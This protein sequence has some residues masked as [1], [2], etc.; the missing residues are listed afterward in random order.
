MSKSI[1]GIGL[2]LVAFA[3]PVVGPMIGLSVL[4]IAATQVGI[5]LTATLLLGPK[6]PSLPKTNPID[7]LY[8]NLD[9]GAPRKIIFGHTAMPT[10]MRYQIF[11]GE[12]DQ[13]FEEIICVASHE[14][15]SIDEIWFDNEL[16][17]SQAGG[18]TERYTT[19][20]PFLWVTTRPLATSAN[21]IAINSTWTASS[22]LTGCAYVYMKMRLIDDGGETNDSPFASGITN[23]M[24]IRGKGAK[25]YDP[26][27]DST[28]T[29]GSGTQRANDQTT[30]TY[31]ST[32]GENPA[33]QLLWY[34]IG[35]KINSK[36]AVGMGMP[37]ARIDL[38]SFITAANACDE[39]VT[40]NGGGTEKRYL[41]AGVLSE[42]DDRKAVVDT[43]CASMNA[44]LRDAGGKISINVIYN[45]LASP[46]VT[47]TEDDILGDEMWE[48]TPPLTDSFNICRGRRVDPSDESLYQMVDFPEVGFVSN[49]GIDRIE[50][51]EFPFVQGNGQA[52]RLAKQRLQRNQYQGRYTAQFNQRALQANVGDPVRLSHVGLGWTNKLFRVIAQTVTR[53]SVIKLVLLE[54]NA[55]IYQ[56]DNDEE[57]AVLPGT[58]TVYDPRN[59]PILVGIGQARR[60]RANELSDIDFR[61]WTRTAG[62]ARTRRNSLAGYAAGL[63]PWHLELSPDTA[64]VRTAT[65]PNVPVVA[66]QRYYFSIKA[67]RGTTLGSGS[68]LNLGGDWLLADGTTTVG[69][70]VEGTQQS[71]TSLTAGELPKEIAWSDVAPATAAYVRLRIYTPALASSSGTF[72]IEAPKVTR[73]EPSADVTRYVDGPYAQSFRYDYTGVAEAGEFTRNLIYNLMTAGGPLASGVTWTYLVK[74]GTVNG[75]NNAS[76]VKSMTGTGAGTLAVSSLGSSINIV[77]VT[78]TAASGKTGTS[79]VTLIKTLAAAPTGGGGGGSPT[80]IFSK[81]SGYF[82]NNTTTFVDVTGS[83]TATTT[84]G[85]TTA[86]ITAS[87]NFSPA[88]G[89]DGAWEIAAKVQRNITG[90]WTDKGSLDT[91]ITGYDA[92]FGIPTDGTIELSVSDTGLTGGT[93]YSWRIVARQSV[94][95]ARNHYVT[96]NVTIVG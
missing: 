90:V 85:V 33:L 54:E 66:G 5:A 29:G 76:G 74:T 13:Y 37:P 4:A 44:I 42:A 26:R 82:A 69:S 94:G 87:L 92:E 91:C 46:V 1:I 83:M 3:I 50:T 86:T 30:W 57:P 32:S 45:D 95:G 67:Q 17:W 96:G 88:A 77:E 28:V 79:T 6:T 68:R 22:T 10:D 52:Q 21:G 75:F 65:S 56:W 12:D 40:K 7:R 51:I 15:S 11:S 48:Q 36:L 80:T 9:I 62:I 81:T 27:L 61:T 58:P 84:S 59:N 55:A 72:R 19:W 34:L 20:G 49:D 31:S 23:R 78:G 18:I 93:S 41:S 43:L 63:M 25:L 35:W 60:A 16:A 14:V 71:P 38:P 64:T 47:F 8:A 53:E 24:T 39:L 73:N 89:S 70:F 2:A